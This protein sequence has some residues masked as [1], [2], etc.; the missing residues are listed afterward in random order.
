MNKLR[1]V[2]VA[3]ALL[4]ASV[5]SLSTTADAR[6]FGFGGG[7][8]HG[9]FGHGG[10]GHGGFGRVGFGGGGWRGG[11]GGGGWGWG[12]AGLGLGLAAGALAGAALASPYYGYG[13]GYPYGY[14]DYAYD[15]VPA[16]SYAPAYSY[17]TVYR[18]PY[19]GYRRHYAY[20]P[21]GYGIRHAGYGYGIRHA[22]YGYGIR[23]A[24]YR[25]GYLGRSV[26]FTGPGGDLPGRDMDIAL[27]KPVLFHRAAEQA[28]IRGNPADAQKSG[29]AQS[30]D[31]ETRPPLRGAFFISDLARKPRAGRGVPG[32]HTGRS[33]LEDSPGANLAD[34]GNHRRRSG[35]STACRSQDERQGRAPCRYAVHRHLDRPIGTDSNSAWAQRIG[36]LHRIANTQSTTP[37]GCAFG[38]K[39]AGRS[40]AAPPAPRL[41]RRAGDGNARPSHAP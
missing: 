26:G 39:R 36:L 32:R 34:K 14:D 25:A 31:T 20:R 27:G 41:G 18:A 7:F 1:T 2:T 22:G 35:A 15:Y 4:V 12:G 28:G 16:Y 33:R 3:A 40:G 23:H 24:G 5:P 13:Y 29:Q 37:V 11:W 9:G 21:Y 10:F 30:D 19:W 6:P 8:G 38:A 17:R